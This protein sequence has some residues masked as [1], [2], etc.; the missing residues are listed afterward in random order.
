MLS[1]SENAYA[2][3]HRARYDGVSA[4]HDPYGPMTI[5]E[6]LRKEW[7]KGWDDADREIMQ[8]YEDYE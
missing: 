6:D 7:L 3:G 8:P 4:E 1:P 5:H 2:N